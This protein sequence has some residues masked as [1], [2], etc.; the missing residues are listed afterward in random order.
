LARKP[1]SLKRTFSHPG[2]IAHWYATFDDCYNTVI[3]LF[4]GEFYRHFQSALSLA[5][6]ACVAQ[7]GLLNQFKAKENF[8]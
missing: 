5:Q 7:P 1:I 6:T 3:I 4:Y 8:L 2:L